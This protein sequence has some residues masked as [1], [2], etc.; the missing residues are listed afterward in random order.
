MGFPKLSSYNS[1]ERRLITK[2]KIQVLHIKHY[3]KEVGECLA[4]VW[5]D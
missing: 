2:H 5:E 4:F 1:L 3:V